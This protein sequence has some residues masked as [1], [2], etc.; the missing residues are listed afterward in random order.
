MTTRKQHRAEDRIERAARKKAARFNQFVHKVATR[1]LENPKEFLN[2]T[3]CCLPDS[4]ERPL[5]EFLSEGQQLCG[6]AAVL[7]DQGVLEKLLPNWG[8]SDRKFPIVMMATYVREHFREDG[9][10]RD[11]YSSGSS[12]W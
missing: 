10:R 8:C 2:S 5:E 12:N 9:S 11:T 3:F 6:G 4:L 1:R 7:F